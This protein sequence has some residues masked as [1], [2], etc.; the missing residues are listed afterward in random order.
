MH[1]VIWTLILSS[2][3][4]GVSAEEMVAELLGAFLGSTQAA[5]HAMQA[6]MPHLSKPNIK[7]EHKPHTADLIWTNPA[8]MSRPEIFRSGSAVRE[9]RRVS[10]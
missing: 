8:S 7:Q 9:L 5:R 3:S 10:W 4:R 1:H 2:S 6:I